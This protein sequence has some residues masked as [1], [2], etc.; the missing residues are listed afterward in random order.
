M[1]ETYGYS[2][3]VMQLFKHPHNMGEIKNP[4]GVGKVG[5]VLCGDLM[6]MYIKVG[7]NKKGQDIIKDAKVK[8]FGCIAAIST[9]SV[10]TDMIKGKTIEEVMKL[11]EDDIVKVLGGL[12]PVK[13]HCSVLATEALR[14]AVYDYY[15]KNK[16]FI[17]KDLHAAHK[18]IKAVRESIEH[19]H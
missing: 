19:V 2:K 4:D 5:N 14:E 18:R 17:S 6:W 3:K 7:K 15:K 9:S 1:A 13:Y 11:R 10:L 8:T 16:K 12:P